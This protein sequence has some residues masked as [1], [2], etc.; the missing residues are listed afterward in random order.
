MYQ[1][2]QREIQAPTF[3]KAQL[4]GK[5]HSLVVLEKI[6]ATGNYIVTERASKATSD[7]IY[8]YTGH[9]Y[10]ADILSGME[11]DLV[12]PEKPLKRFSD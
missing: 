4:D 9:Y 5:N 1:S 2:Y 8:A 12:D 3:D 6:A 7:F 10:T 11:K